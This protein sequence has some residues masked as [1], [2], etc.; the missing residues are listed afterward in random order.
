MKMSILEFSYFSKSKQEI[1]K[2][3]YNNDFRS[4]GMEL[5][6]FGNSNSTFTTIEEENEFEKDLP[7]FPIPFPCDQATLFFLHIPKCGGTAIWKMLLNM[8]KILKE[9]LEN[10][11]NGNVSSAKS[12]TLSLCRRLDLLWYKSIVWSGIRWNKEEF[13]KRL[14]C[15]NLIS[16]HV[17]VSVEALFSY[18]CNSSF[19]DN[20]VK[21]S[22]FRGKH[23]NTG[24]KR[25]VR[26]FFSMTILREPIIRFISSYFY[27][28]ERI[29]IKRMDIWQYLEWTVRNKLDNLETRML[30]GATSASFYPEE[31]KLAIHSLNETG[32]LCL[33]KQN[34]R[35]MIVV[36]LMEQF[37]DSLEFI[38]RALDLKAK[39]ISVFNE[40]EISNIQKYNA[41]TLLRENPGLKEAIRSIHRMDLEIYAYAKRLF[42]WRKQRILNG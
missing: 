31:Q 29:S 38:D 11:G 17:D 34:L 39:G 9:L 18:L 5:S 26:F 16:G 33:A 2:N 13:K 4:N 32:L 8:S 27:Y 40:I 23:F 15:C 1:Y 3:G 19:V 20:T 25:E 14:G 22:L 21:E 37:N 12:F 30:S 7:S 10:T 36:G 24:D 6:D 28:N 42:Q 35:R 41:M